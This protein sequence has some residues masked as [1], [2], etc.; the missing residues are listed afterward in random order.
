MQPFDRLHEICY[1]KKNKIS[2]K[3]KYCMG[4]K[5]KQENYLDYVFMRNPVYQWKE[6]EDG[7]VCIIV[8]W[9][10]F[11]HWLAHKIFRKPK[12]SEIAM[13]KLGSFVWKQLDGKRNMY[14]V[15]ELVRAEFG[16]EAEPVYERLIK[17][18]EIMKE[19]KFVL[20]K[21]GKRHG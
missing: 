15:S 13:D 17:F 2:R 21:E 11:Y 3:A 12:Q 4:R 20:L 6:K 1:S 19:N 14:E 5:K 18:V 10:G 7:L 8:E 16:K 9:K